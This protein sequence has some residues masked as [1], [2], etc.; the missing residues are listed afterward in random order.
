[1]HKDSNATREAVRVTFCTQFRRL[2]LQALVITGCPYQASE[3]VLEAFDEMDGSYVASPEFAYEASELAT[4]KSGLRKVAFEIKLHALDETGK[5]NKEAT[6]ASASSTASEVAIVT[7]E[8]LFTSLLQL[9]A[10]YRALLL[11][12]LYEGYRAHEVA[13]LLRLP[14]NTIQN[15]FAKALLS[16][17][18][19]FNGTATDDHEKAASSTSR[20]GRRIAQDQD[21]W[22]QCGATVTS[23]GVDKCR[24]VRS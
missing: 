19:I 14:S 1:M 11:L 12:H 16:L 8:K 13:L 6:N 4:I 17:V 5:S 7:M 24:S 2:H 20:F 23:V 15:G 3:C 9:N 18:S 21:I 10:F 22:S